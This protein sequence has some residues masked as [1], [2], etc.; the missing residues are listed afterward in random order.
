MAPSPAGAVGSGSEA[1]SLVLLVSPLDAERLA[2]AK[3]FADLDV[4]I[5]AQ[6]SEIPSGATEAG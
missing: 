4:S 3:A 2:Y 6:P 5:S 1:P